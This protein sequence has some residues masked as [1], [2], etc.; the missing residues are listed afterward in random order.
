MIMRKQTNQ[1]LTMPLTEESDNRSLDD[2]IFEENDF[3]S[4]LKES[5]DPDLLLLLEND[6]DTY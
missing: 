5:L 2:S 1:N 6:F 3:G 4:Q